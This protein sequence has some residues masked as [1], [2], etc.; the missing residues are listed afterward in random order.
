M[1]W[2]LPNLVKLFLSFLP[3][4]A[5][6]GPLQDLY[7]SLVVHD[8]SWRLLQDVLLETANEESGAISALHSAQSDKICVE[9]SV[10]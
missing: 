6:N 10:Q 5:V 2:S 8:S 9:D 1:I 4:L 7:N 3:V